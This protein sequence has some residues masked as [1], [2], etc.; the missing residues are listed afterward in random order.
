MDANPFEAVPL[1][2]ALH[3][4]LGE[5]RCALEAAGFEVRGAVI[6]ADVRHA[7]APQFNRAAVAHPMDDWQSHLDLLEGAQRVF[8]A[9]QRGG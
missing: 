8:R 6:V 5:A 1:Q 3:L 7:D 4:A 2:E 9:K